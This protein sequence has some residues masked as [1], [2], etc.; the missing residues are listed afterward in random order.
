MAQR[1][2]QTG[3]TRRCTVTM[4]TRRNAA[5]TFANAVTEVR[6]IPS[7]Y[8]RVEAAAEL[9]SERDPHAV[10]VGPVMMTRA[11]MVV[12]AMLALMLVGALVIV[13]RARLQAGKRAS[14]DP[15]ASSW[16]RGRQP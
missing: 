1:R 11:G 12:T 8:H 14:S 6:V 3:V 13:V 5:G 7:G 16:G 9:R 10:R 2:L 4:L 15:T